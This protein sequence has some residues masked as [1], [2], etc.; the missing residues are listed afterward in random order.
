MIWRP[1]MAEC[2]ELGLVDWQWQEAARLAGANLQKRESGGMMNDL[3][4]RFGEWAVVT[5]ASSGIG[6][7][8]ARKLAGAR[9]NLVLVARRIDLLKELRRR[10][11]DEHGVEIRCVQ[12]D[13]SQDGCLDPLVGA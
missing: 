11:T 4:T 1:L 13:L 7:T 8:F 9:M 6:A 5:G 12:V 3:R 10:L 2:D